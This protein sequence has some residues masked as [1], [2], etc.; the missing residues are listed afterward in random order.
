MIDTDIVVAL[1]FFDSCL[2]LIFSLLFKVS[3]IDLFDMF[4]L[5]LHYVAYAFSIE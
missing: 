1:L 5:I 4:M 2:L 3:L